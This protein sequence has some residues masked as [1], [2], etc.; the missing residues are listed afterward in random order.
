MP[1][2]FE[3]F[4]SALAEAGYR[5]SEAESHHAGFG[6]WWVIIDAV[7]RARV[8]WDGTDGWLIVQREESGDWSDAWIGKN[9]AEQTPERLVSVLRCL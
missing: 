9:P 5:Q 7:P 2:T 1:P 3:H 8:V 4:R 6:S